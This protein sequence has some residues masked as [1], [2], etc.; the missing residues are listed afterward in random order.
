VGLRFL[1]LLPV[2][3]YKQIYSEFVDY[4]SKKIDL[5]KIY[6]TFASGLLY[7]KSDYNTM[8]KKDPYFD[9]LYYLKEDKD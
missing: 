6:S 8:L 3:N 9:L 4:V 2:K 1:P 7:T 5:C